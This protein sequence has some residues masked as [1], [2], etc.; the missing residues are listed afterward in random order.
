MIALGE[1]MRSRLVAHGLDANK[2]SVA[3][4]WADCDSTLPGGYRSVQP[5][6]AAGLSIIYSGN[7][8][9]AH[10]ATTIA[11]AMA[12][13]SGAE[14]LQFVFGGGGSRHAWIR[15]FCE[16]SGIRN[17]QFLPYCERDELN[18]RL[19]ACD[20]GLVTQNADSAGSVVPSKSYGIMAA[21]R[22]VL[23]IGPRHS[24]T[25]LMIERYGCGWQIDCGDVNSLVE[26]LRCL[27]ENKELVYAAGERAYQTFFN[28]YQRSLGVARISAGLL[29]DM[30]QE[31]ESLAQVVN[32]AKHAIA[33]GS[34]TRTGVVQNG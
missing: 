12:A 4:N 1:C 9:R 8:G 24:T 11:D 15:D 28:H 19:A 29:Q 6:P 14:E 22:P 25:A 5:L 13:L 21:G 16:N 20:I 7:F 31:A 32:C 10:D 26:L 27:S 34:R 30:G 3:E 2:I 18:A 23:Y 17:V 33:E